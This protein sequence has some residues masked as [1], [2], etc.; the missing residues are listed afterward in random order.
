MGV[1]WVIDRHGEQYCLACSGGTDSSRSGRWGVR[2]GINRVQGWHRAAVVALR[3]AQRPTAAAQRPTAV[4]AQ[5]GTPPEWR[6]T[7][8]GARCALRAAWRPTAEEARRGIRAGA[9]AHQLLPYIV[10]V[11]P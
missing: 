9:G 8:V 5:R 2:L 4:E 11:L 1:V 10:F 7:A 3:A 6:L